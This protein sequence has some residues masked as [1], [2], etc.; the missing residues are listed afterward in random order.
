MEYNV[1]KNLRT[2][3]KYVYLQTYWGTPGGTLS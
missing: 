2:R 3:K 1:E